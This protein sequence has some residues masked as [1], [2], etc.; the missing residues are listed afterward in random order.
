MQLLCGR[1]KLETFT[2]R[3][4][5]YH[6]FDSQF[7]ATSQLH[8]QARADR[9]RS[10]G[11]LRADQIIIFDN[12][13]R[14]KKDEAILKCKIPI[15][16]HNFEHSYEFLNSYDMEKSAIAQKSPIAIGAIRKK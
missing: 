14:R 5:I 7:S 9:R 16:S 6:F 15:S 13:N 4:S 11:K 12:H 2:L 1:Q 3:A 8:S 10:I